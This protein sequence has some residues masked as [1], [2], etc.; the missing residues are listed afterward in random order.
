[1]SFFT[2]LNI[3]V[4]LV[5]FCGA[6][7]PE[8]RV[9]SKLYFELAPCAECNYCHLVKDTLF[10]LFVALVR[11][12]K[13]RSFYENVLYC[14]KSCFKS[15]VFQ[16]ITN[17]A[18]NIQSYDSTTMNKLVFGDE[19]ADKQLC[20]IYF[21]QFL[22]QLHERFGIRHGP[23]SIHQKTVTIVYRSGRRAIINFEE[24]YKRLE[25][26][27]QSK[28]Y[29]LNVARMEELSFKQQLQLMDETDILIACHG[30]AM[31]NAAFMNRKGVVIE[32]FPYNF[33][34]GMFG[35]YI[36]YCRPD[37]RYRQWTLP[38]KACFATVP[39]DKQFEY[40]YWRD[41]A[42]NIDPEYLINIVDKLTNRF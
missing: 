3:L 42:V 39:M 18:V 20:A 38:K 8:Q 5:V 19:L 1:M 26:Y 15:E 33:K 22:A 32:I 11:I 30:A 6:T 36:E 12:G 35:R 28:H 21:P 25:K 34:Y 40:R 10:P 16:V 41:Q 37:L 9:K 24:V 23:G 7:T 17:H 31:T 4:L 2:K 29:R 13:Q 27:C 14:N